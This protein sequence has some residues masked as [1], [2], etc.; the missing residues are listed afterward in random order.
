MQL[1]AARLV[2]AGPFRD[3]HLPFADDDGRPR[4]FT[5]VYGGAGVGK[6]TLLAALQATRPGH[7]VALSPGM[8]PGL[9]FDPGSPRPTP[10]AI[11]DYWLGQD[12]PERPHPL[13]VA[14]PGVRIGDSD[15]ED[16]FLRREQALFERRAGSGGF[17]FASLPSH[18]FFS[19]QPIGISAPL[20]TI[21]RY[22]V[23]GPT[24]T[25]EASRADL[26][27]ETKQA[28]AYAAIGASLARGGA[29]RGRRL[30]LL[31]SAMHRAVDHLAVLAG[32][33]Y[34]GLDAASFEPVFLD[35]DGRERFFDVL[36]TRARHLVAFAAL[37]TRLLWAAYPGHDP[38]TSEGIFAIDDVELHQD[39][40]AQA[41]L[42]TALCQ[43]LP[44]VQWIVTTSSSA[45]AASVD[46]REVIALRRVSDED[47]VE[48]YV[49]E[50]ARTH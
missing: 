17:A 23:R 38:R 12:E 25:D 22:D 14:S 47:D 13:R 3:L 44:G 49:G 36:P 43:A 9:G 1:V 41:G 2:R 28:L 21:A 50:E 20:R 8:L 30:D 11:C 27:R 48:L 37:S 34:R 10:Q 15:Q 39:R 6:S 7:T 29:D 33:S 35:A 4:R 46:S 24:A 42:A 5:V 26:T 45:V 16:A 32:F 40:A 18:R 31:G 19:R